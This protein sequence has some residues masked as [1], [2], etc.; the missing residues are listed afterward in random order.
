MRSQRA[1]FG[2]QES[3]VL[4]HF[5]RAYEGGLGAFQYFDYFP[6]RFFALAP[7]AE[8]HTHPVAVHGVRRVAFGDE[9]RGAAFIG[10]ER[11]LS[12]ALALEYAGQYLSL[13]VQ[14]EFSFL[15]LDEEAVFYHFV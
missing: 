14:L 12:V 7:R 11:V 8:C 4:G 1:R 3:V 5:Q 15:R 10:R 6:F 2:E 9:D 13:S